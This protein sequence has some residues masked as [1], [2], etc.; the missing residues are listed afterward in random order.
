MFPGASAGDIQKLV[1]LVVSGGGGHGPGTED[2]HPTEH[3]KKRKAQYTLSF[4]IQNVENDL[5]GAGLFAG[6]PQ[7]LLV[8]EYSAFF[9]KNSILP[10]SD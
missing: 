3:Q 5:K 10:P 1:S 8:K 9:W 6:D 7:T 2:Q 4:H